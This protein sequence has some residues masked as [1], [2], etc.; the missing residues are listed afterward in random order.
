[1]P[2]LETFTWPTLV[3]I[4]CRS[5]VLLW[6]RWVVR[7]QNHAQKDLDLGRTEVIFSRRFCLGF[8]ASSIENLK[9]NCVLILFDGLYIGLH[10]SLRVL[11]CVIVLSCPP[12]E[13]TAL[14][15]VCLIEDLPQ[16]S[17]SNEVTLTL[18]SPV[19]TAWPI[20]KVVG[21]S[22]ERVLSH[23]SVLHSIY[24]VLSAVLRVKDDWERPFSVG[25]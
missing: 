9:L 12:S 3:K 4:S 11:L 22:T 1:M 8:F 20:A 23:K 7:L 5:E 19:Q 24:Q 14:S 17:H 18:Q 16:S 25:R 10:D 13:F 2:F 6:S 15:Y 21:R